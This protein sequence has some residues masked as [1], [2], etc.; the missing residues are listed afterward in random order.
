MTDPQFY[1]LASRALI[2]L[3]GEETLPLINDI[4]TADISSLPGD[5]ARRGLADP[6]GA[7]SFRYGVQ[8]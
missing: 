8:P 6:A 3:S 5:E 1:R 7:C 2:R 4:V